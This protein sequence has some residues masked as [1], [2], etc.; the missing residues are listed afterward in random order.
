MS[1]IKWDIIPPEI[2]NDTFYY[3]IIN[4]IKNSSDI[5][6]ILEIG[7]SS[8]SGSTEA[9]II[10]KMKKN[11]KLFSIEVCTERFDLLKNRYT[12][13][14][15]FFPYNVSSVGIDEFPEKKKII[16]FH[17][18]I[19]TTLNN[20]PINMVLGWYDNDIEYIT[21]NNIPQNGIELI[22]KKIIL[23]YLIVF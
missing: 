1:K 4:L 10:G 15:N 5:K 22:K 3:S 7:A 9:F 12:F 16:D 13:D 2:K 6:N 19:K 17:N 23:T 20:Y 21:K 18:N 11:I 8:G 14:S